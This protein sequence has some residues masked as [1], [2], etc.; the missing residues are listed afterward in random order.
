MAASI[1]I[2]DF[3]TFQNSVDNV[4]E[5]DY[6][7]ID[8]I[9]EAAQAFEKTTYQCVYIIDYFKRGFLYVSRN[10]GKLC[11]GDA[12]KIKDFGYDFYMKYVP[13]DDLKMLLEINTKGFQKFNTLPIGERKGYVISYNFHIKGESGNKGMLV[14]HK[15]TPLVL[16]REG[17]IWL[18]MCTISL[19]AGHER[20]KVIM[21]QAGADKYFEYELWSHS[22]VE[23][24][25]IRLSTSERD[26]LYLSTQGY[27][28]DD[29]AEIVCRSVDTVKAAK[30]SI[31]SKM[32]VKNIAEALTYAQN[33]QLI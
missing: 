6:A 11:G 24:P 27:T 9:I 13:E 28:M 33:H 31:F 1:E 23:K 18:A 22:W 32:N 26:V 10:I 7:S 14:N 30:R 8:R 19:A 3:F 15:L 29:I 12:D 17:R 25:E 21:K 20:G 4:N 5:N 2:G 16:T